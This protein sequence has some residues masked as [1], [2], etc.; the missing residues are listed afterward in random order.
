MID[1]IVDENSD[2]SNEYVDFVSHQE[3]KFQKQLN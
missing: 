2:N 3:K 1:V